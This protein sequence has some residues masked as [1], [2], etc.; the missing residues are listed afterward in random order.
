MRYQAVKPQS[1]CRQMDASVWAYLH[2]Y[3]YLHIYTRTYTWVM[4]I[5]ICVYMLICMYICMR[6]YEYIYAYKYIW[7]YI[8]IN[9]CKDTYTYIHPHRYIYPDVD[10]T[11]QR[12]L[13]ATQP[14]FPGTGELPEFPQALSFGLMAPCSRSR[15]WPPSPPRAAGSAWADGGFVGTVREVRALLVRPS[16]QGPQSLGAYMNRVPLISGS[17]HMENLM[18][19]VL[20]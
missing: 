11:R 10:R 2:I 4:Y 14:L 5:Q 15:A 6:T 3:I 7:P 12:L 19:T 13:N 16:L 8:Y 20:A 17:P 18:N 9:T 1:L